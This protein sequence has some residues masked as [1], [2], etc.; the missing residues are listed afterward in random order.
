MKM[1][2]PAAHIRVARPSGDL[3]AAEAFYS[4]GLALEVL[5]RS[6]AS[7]N[8]ESDLLML[9][10]PG[11][12]WHLELTRHPTASVAPR[13]TA[14]DLLVLYLGGPIPEGTVERL[15]RSGGRRVASHNPYWD[16]HGVTIEDPDG[17]RLVL[18][19]RGWSNAQARWMGSC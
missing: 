11:T 17:Y 18:C 5:H 10:W 2:K 3:A 6:T 8:D 7:G 9:G 16:R 4:G 13:P 1:A 15:E 12:Y 14:D 19:T